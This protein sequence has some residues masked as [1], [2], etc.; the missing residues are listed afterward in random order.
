[1][2]FDQRLVVFDLDNTL[3]VNRL[4]VLE[5]SP[6]RYVPVPYD[7]GL[8]YIYVRPFMEHTLIKCRDDIRNVVILFSA[9]GF[10]YV[11]SIVNLV[12]NPFVRAIDPS[13]QFAAVYTTCDIVDGMKPIGKIS[14]GFGLDESI[15]ID[16]MWG[17]CIGCGSTA[18]HLI[19]PFDPTNAEDTALDYVLDN[20]FFL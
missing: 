5:N 17:Y 7:G 18:Y 14:R 19:T 13:W 4:E 6:Y 15:L 20:P 16:D 1:M 9:G 2:A 12:I 11:H 3:I 8:M 10:D